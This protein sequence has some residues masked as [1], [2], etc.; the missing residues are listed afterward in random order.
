MSQGLASGTKQGEVSDSVLSTVFI[1]HTVSCCV[2][3]S[4]RAQIQNSADRSLP[5]AEER[6]QCR[7]IMSISPEQYMIMYLK[8]PL[9]M[10]Q[11]RSPTNWLGTLSRQGVPHLYCMHTPPV[12]TSKVDCVASHQLGECATLVLDWCIG[13]WLRANFRGFNYDWNFQQPRL[14][15]KHSKKQVR[16]FQSTNGHIGSLP[17]EPIWC[18]LIGTPQPAHPLVSA[19]LL[20]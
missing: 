3:D 4:V 11:R 8:R 5:V 12:W 1:R 15:A 7:Q 2:W 10:H 19:C 18:L 13:W 17:A 6:R 14:V 9:I 20:I 16:S